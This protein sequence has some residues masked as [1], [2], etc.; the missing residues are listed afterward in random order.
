[1]RERWVVISN[2]Q[3]FG[4][5]DCLA[6]LGADID[7]EACDIYAFRDRLAEDPGFFLRYDFALVLPEAREI[8]GFQADALPAS[9]DMPSFVFGGYHPDCCYVFAD[10]EVLDGLIGPYNS[11][12]ALAAFKEGLGA[13]AASRFFTDWMYKAL[14]YDHHWKP[15]R[16]HMI[17]QYSAS[18]LN[19]APLFR[20]LSR[21]GCFMHTNDHPKIE[22]FYAIAQLVLE[23][24]GKRALAGAPLPADRLTGKQWPIYPE[25]GEYL[26]VQGAYLFR[27]SGAMRPLE[28]RDY[29]DAAL[30][31]FGQW[32]KSQLR[33][34]PA[35]QRRLQTIR[36]LIREGL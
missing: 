36:R 5:A 29:L 33:V 21:G 34:I 17:A 20:R 23:S 31:I 16:D 13:E 22:L 30:V 27:P 4:L 35:V 14:G 3:T 6:A 25:I 32:D 9:I 10:G 18:G 26:G 19:I 28:L 2:C 1:M 24:R 12:I 7:V 15:Y 11:M 8:E